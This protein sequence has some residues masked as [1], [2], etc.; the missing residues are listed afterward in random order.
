MVDDP[1][2]LIDLGP[3]FLNI[4]NLPVPEQ[5]TGVDIKNILMSDKSGVVDPTKE[6]VVS[7]FEKHCEARVDSGGYPRRAI[8]T[9]DWTYILNYEP[10][11]MPAG[12]KEVYIERWGNYGDIDPS[13]VKSYFLQEEDNPDFQY[14][15]NLNFGRVPGEELYNKNSDSDM[16]HNL[17]FKKEYTEVVKELRKKLEDYLVETNDPRVNGATFWD[18]YHLDGPPPK[19]K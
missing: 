5:M 13:R 15:F 6:F 1:V 18:D 4:L 17:A 19:K 7:G 14:Y 16:I 3:T 10:Q 2:S 9:K 8:H 11:R 12:D